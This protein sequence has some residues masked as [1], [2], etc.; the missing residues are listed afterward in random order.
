MKTINKLASY[1][2][3]VYAT[4]DD[5]TLINILNKFMCPPQVMD[6]VLKN[7]NKQKD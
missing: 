6:R 3:V 7:L 4:I 2:K 1:T 5:L